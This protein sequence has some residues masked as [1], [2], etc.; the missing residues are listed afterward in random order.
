MPEFL[1]CTLFVWQ[2]LTVNVAVQLYCHIYLQTSDQLL[3][4]SL[5]PITCFISINMFGFQSRVSGLIV[6][7]LLLL[8]LLVQSILLFE[9]SFLGMFTHPIFLHSLFSSNLRPLRSGKLLFLF[10]PLSYQSQKRW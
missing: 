4:F 6:S 10:S 5:F 1:P 7:L 3:E 2:N 8:P 9:M